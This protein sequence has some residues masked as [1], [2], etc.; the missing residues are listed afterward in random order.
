M[1]RKILVPIDVSE[2]AMA[3]FAV[4]LVAQ[5]AALTDGAE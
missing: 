4:F 5:F 2:T 1:F 3:E